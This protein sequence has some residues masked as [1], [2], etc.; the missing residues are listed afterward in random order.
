MVTIF[1]HVVVGDR[2]PLLSIDIHQWSPKTW[3]ENLVR[4]ARFA[5]NFEKH[6]NYLPDIHQLS[7]WDWIISITLLVSDIRGY[8]INLL[9]L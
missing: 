4:Y 1:Y 2:S 6:N 7:A 5:F 9:N 8:N 3:L